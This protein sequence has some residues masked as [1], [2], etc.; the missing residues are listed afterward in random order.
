MNQFATSI[1]ILGREYPLKY[2]VN[3]MKEI[4]KRYGSVE[5]A[6]EGLQGE[7]DVF[8][9][10]DYAIGLVC[11]LATE[12]A[13]SHNFEFPNEEQIP[14][15]PADMAETILTI[16]D[17]GDITPMIIKAINEG[18]GRTVFSEEGEKNTAGA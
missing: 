4:Q 15:F 3:A 11:I 14:D 16:A 5:R 6:A 18:M 7:R 17:L 8:E 9:K 10:L 12:G 1:T 2:S 13:R